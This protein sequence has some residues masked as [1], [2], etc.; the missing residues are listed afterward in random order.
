MW[1]YRCLVSGGASREAR[2]ATLGPFP[3]YSIADA[4]A[5][6]AALNECTE[7]G[8]D[9]AQKLRERRAA[10]MTVAEAH[11]IEGARVGLRPII[12]IALAPV[13]HC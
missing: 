8:I 1:K 2:K 9:P 10:G 12:G 5:W 6:A 3:T 13:Y 7:R 4:R 11:R